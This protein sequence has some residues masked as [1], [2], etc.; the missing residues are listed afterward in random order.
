MCLSLDFKLKEQ[1]KM[2]IKNIIFLVLR[3]AMGLHTCQQNSEGEGYEPHHG[4]GSKT[5]ISYC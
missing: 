3:E 1:T 5:N 2:L 4:S